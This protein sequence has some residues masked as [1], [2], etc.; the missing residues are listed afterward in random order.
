MASQALYLHDPD[1]SGIE[2]YW[3]RP[4]AEPRAKQTAR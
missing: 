2:L 3:D 4:R 1:G